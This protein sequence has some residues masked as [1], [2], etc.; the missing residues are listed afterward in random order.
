[1]VSDEILGKRDRRTTGRDDQI[2]RSSVRLDRLRRVTTGGNEGGG[3]HLLGILLLV[4]RVTDDGYICSQ[5]RGEDDCEMSE[6]SKTNNTD[7]LGSLSGTV[8][9]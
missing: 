9:N 2:K 1:M 8:L 3:S 4:V 6:T 7:V 5:S